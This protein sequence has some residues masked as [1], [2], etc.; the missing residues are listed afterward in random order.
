[1]H[2][3]PLIDIIVGQEHMLLL[4]IKPEVQ[5]LQTPINEQVRQLATVHWKYA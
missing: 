1:M 2:T 4:K 5:V 3:E